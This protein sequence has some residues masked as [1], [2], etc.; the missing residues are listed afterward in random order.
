MQFILQHEGASRALQFATLAG[1][2]GAAA[3]NARPELAGVDSVFWVEPAADGSP[4]RVL[5]RSDAVLAVMTHLGGGWRALAKV[6]RIVPRVS[7]DV[8]YRIV[9]RFRY[10]VFGRDQSCLLPTPE[11]RAR[12]LD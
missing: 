4:P 9:A 3:R 2:T 8:L 10:N 1:P 6:G 5:V 11:Q 7:R 12:F